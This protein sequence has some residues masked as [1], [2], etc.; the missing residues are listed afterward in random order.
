MQITFDTRYI[1][2]YSTIKNLKKAVEKFE[3][4][5]YVVSVT[6]EG[7]FYPIFIGEEALQAGVHFHNFPVTN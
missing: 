2:S 6:E 3:E 7:R 5:R 1:K 4:C